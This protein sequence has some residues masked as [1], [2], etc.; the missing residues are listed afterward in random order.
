MSRPVPGG[1]CR[2]AVFLATILSAHFIPAFA[3]EPTVAGLHDLAVFDP[4]A[5]ER[6]LPAVKFRDVPGDP[7]S[8]TGG[9]LEVDIPPAVHVHRYY[10]SGDKEFQ[11]PIITGGPTVVVANHPKTGKRMYIDVVLPAGAPRIAHNKHGITYVYKTQRV[12]VKFQKLPFCDETAAVKIHAGRGWKRDMQEK[13]A[14]ASSHVHECLANSQMVHSI[15]ELSGETCDFLKGA[16]VS[17]GSLATRGGDGLKT[18][19][20]MIPGVTYVKSMAEQEAHKVYASEI[21]SAGLSRA[22]NETPFV[23]TNR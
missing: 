13:H 12:E 1:V 15:K 9:G 4:G 3:V 14:Q 2:V 5:H 8:G 17:V 21:R 20:N 18:L 23:P 16:K 11:G 7:K 19:T 22:R 10:Y 6:G